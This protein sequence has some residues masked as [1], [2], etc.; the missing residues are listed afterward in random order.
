MI[1]NFIHIIIQIIPWYIHVI[2]H[3]VHVVANE[4]DRGDSTAAGG[5]MMQRER[6][7]HCFSLLSI[8]EW[9]KSAWQQH[10]INQT[11]HQNIHLTTTPFSLSLHLLSWNSNK[12]TT[13]QIIRQYNNN[14]NNNNDNNNKTIRCAH[15]WVKWK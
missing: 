11:E 2:I 14:N 7:R 6:W 12:K 1:L 10:Y 4:G 3:T 13:F 9:M 15:Q 8:V 5:D